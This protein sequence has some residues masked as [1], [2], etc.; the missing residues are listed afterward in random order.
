M[1]DDTERMPPLPPTAPPS[2]DD[3]VIPPRPPLP[4]PTDVQ[5]PEPAFP[6]WVVPA[7]PVTGGRPSG[8]TVARELERV[9]SRTWDARRIARWALVAYAIVLVL[10]AWW[11]SP[12]DRGAAPLI[13]AVNEVVPPVTLDRVEFAANI[14]Y[15]VPLG[16]L[17]A[18]L[19][20]QRHLIVPIAVVT[21]VT[22][23]AGQA[24][25]LDARVPSVLD[26]VANVTG[27]CVG[28]LTVAIVEWWRAARAA[29]VPHMESRR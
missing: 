11:P 18:L 10:I 9:A 24:L 2:A 26:I 6:G 8:R 28:L 14:L 7:R 20:T 29:T 16:A 5:R 19:L 23:E 22:I 15:F 3:I 1:T 21:T 12:V 13:G 25:L 27:A 17:L 4:A